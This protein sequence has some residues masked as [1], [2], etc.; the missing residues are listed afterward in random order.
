MRPPLSS[1]SLNYLIS[2]EYRE[3]VLDHLFA[4]EFGN[5]G[6]ADHFYLDAHRS[7]RWTGL[8]MVMGSHGVNHN[9]L[10]KLPLADQR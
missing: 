7:E 10:S 3:Y 6:S 1:V 2:Y 4:E 9:V 5:D 8:G